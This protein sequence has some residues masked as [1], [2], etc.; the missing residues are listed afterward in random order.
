MQCSLCLHGG[1]VKMTKS[2]LE[3]GCRFVNSIHTL[4]CSSPIKHT[5]TS[6]V[7]EDMCRENRT[8]FFRLKRDSGPNWT[9]VCALSSSVDPAPNPC[10]IFRGHLGSLRPFPCWNGKKILEKGQPISAVLLAW[11]PERRANSPFMPSRA[12]QTAHS[13]HACLCGRYLRIISLRWQLSRPRR[14]KRL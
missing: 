11:V 9:K 14:H 6:F 5:Q 8:L 2:C 12:V 1:S 4:F 3:A 10:A 7:A 13:A